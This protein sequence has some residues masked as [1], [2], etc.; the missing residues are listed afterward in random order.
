MEEIV[1]YLVSNASPGNLQL[2]FSAGSGCMHLT[3]QC[4]T[5][6]MKPG[7]FPVPVTHCS[8]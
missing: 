4:R 2:R 1:W 3:G 8:T 6:A 7:L 5:W